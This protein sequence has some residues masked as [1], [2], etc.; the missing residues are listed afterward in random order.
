MKKEP[1]YEEAYKELTAIVRD[2]EQENIPVD[3]MS[4]MIRRATELIALCRSKLLA[5]EEE[6]GKV[7]KDFSG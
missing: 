4:E 5:T 3:K 6:T 2:M 7:L 1:T